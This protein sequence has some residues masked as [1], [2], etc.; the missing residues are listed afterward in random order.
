MNN[1]KVNIKF[2]A[3]SVFLFA[4]VTFT[5]QSCKEKK[6]EVVEE[7]SETKQDTGTVSIGGPRTE[8]W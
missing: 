4:G 1:K 7:I 3:W 2:I 8:V 6:K 5:F